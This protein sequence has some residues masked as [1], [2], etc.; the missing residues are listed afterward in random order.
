MPRDAPPRSA[1]P[2]AAVLFT[3]VTAYASFYLCRSNVEAAFPLLQTAFGFHKA[4]LGLLASVPIA[5]YGVGKVVT[6]ALG[7]VIGGKRLLLLGIAG[8]VA[9]TAAFGASS[10]LGAFL[11]CASINRLFQSGGW[12]GAVGV[13]ARRFERGRHGAVMG[14]LSTSYLLGDVLAIHVCAWVAATFSGWRWLFFINPALLATVGVFVAG[15]LPGASAEHLASSPPTHARW[16]RRAFR[17]RLSANSSRRSRVDR[18]SGS[19]WRC[20]CSSRSCASAS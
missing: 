5:L 18:P 6:G 14:V 15:A 4:D 12:A 20:R 13:V 9:A 17:G 16:H 8:S 10:T 2:T 7:E 1:A 3:L 11:V 19:R